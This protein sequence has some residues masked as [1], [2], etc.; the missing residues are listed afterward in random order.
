MDRVCRGIKL[1]FGPSICE[2]FS[3]GRVPE[4]L[5]M[6]TTPGPASGKGPAAAMADPPSTF[7]PRS[8]LL[9]DLVLPTLALRGARRDDLAVRGC[10]GFGAW[11]GCV[12]AGV[13]WGAAW[14]YLAHDPRREQSRRYASGWIVAA[15]TFGI[16][17]AGIQGWMQWPS[18]FEGKLMTN[19]TPGV[20]RFVPISR[21]YGFLWMFLA[22]AKWAGIGVLSGLDRLP[23]GNAGLALVRADCLRADR[24]VPRAVPDRALPAVLLAAL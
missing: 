11:K 15:L 22:G 16:G 3:L 24:R 12:F 4:S 5:L 8:D 2:K 17:I 21:A 7:T 1:A 18:L 13:T 20:D 9:H 23:E 14:W 6:N 19:A 10:S